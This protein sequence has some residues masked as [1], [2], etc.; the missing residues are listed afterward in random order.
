MIVLLQRPKLTG[1][2]CL[3]AQQTM[4]ASRSPA[5]NSSP[6]AGNRRCQLL[7]NLQQLI[8]AGLQ[9]DKPRQA[10]L[11]RHRGHCKQSP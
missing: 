1:A 2:V 10:G 4:S 6:V 11:S 3:Q 7:P 8:L 5:G 9:D